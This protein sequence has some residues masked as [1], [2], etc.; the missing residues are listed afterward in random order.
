MGI[1]TGPTPEGG[2]E[3]GRLLAS[4]TANLARGMYST[5]Q[6]KDSAFPAGPT[7]SLTIKTRCAPCLPCPAA[8]ISG[9]AAGG[10]VLMCNATFLAV[11]HIT[12]ELGCVTHEGMSYRRL[13]ATRA[14]WYMM[15]R[16]VM[17]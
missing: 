16:C 3:G 13:N 7:Y 11:Q 15:W 4:Q 9:A 5:P 1:A 8:V 12:E 10:Q 14:P 2:P 17:S 6:S